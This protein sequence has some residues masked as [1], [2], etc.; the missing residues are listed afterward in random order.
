MRIG[1]EKAIDEQLLD[2]GAQGVA[3]HDLALQAGGLNGLD[4]ADLDA[5]D[6]FHGQD[7]RGR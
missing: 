6:E 4:V 5:L 7:P 2:D 3:G 1:V